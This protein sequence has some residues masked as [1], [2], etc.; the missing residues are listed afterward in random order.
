MARRTTNTLTEVELEF[1]HILWATK[2]A[3]PEDMQKA[4]LQNN[5]SLTGGSIRKMLLILM[6]KSY[7][8]RRKEGK[9]YLYRAAVGNAAAKRSMVGDLLD[10]AFGGSAALMV[11]ALLDRGNVPAEDLDH[12]E[13]LIAARKKGGSK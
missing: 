1:M 12:I 11:A 4:L 9:K 13:R 3:S 7:V 5:R 2:E 10:R 8:S 6:N